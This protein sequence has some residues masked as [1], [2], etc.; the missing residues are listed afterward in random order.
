MANP[1]QSA[2][3]KVEWANHHIR[4]LEEWLSDFIEIHEDSIVQN[5]NA[6]VQGATSFVGT[7]FSVPDVSET[8]LIIG[9]AVHNLRSAL[10]HIAYEI[11]LPFR[12]PKDSG[13]PTDKDRQTMVTQRRYREMETVAPDLAAIIA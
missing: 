7:A 1:F 5:L 8:T 12:D 2:I 3:S 10:D 11:L 4:H 6:E 9:D 13:F